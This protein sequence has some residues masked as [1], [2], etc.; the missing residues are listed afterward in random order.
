MTHGRGS[1][2]KAFV[3]LSAFIVVSVGTIGCTSRPTTEEAL[4]EQAFDAIK[5]NDWEAYQK[6]TITY[7]D[8]LLKAHK[9][10]R[11]EE[12]MSYAGD[13]LKP[14]ELQSQRE[15]FD[16]AVA[17]GK[18]QIDFRRTEFLGA[19]PVFLESMME[20]LTAEE[21]VPF[22]IYALK[23]AEGGMQRETRDLFP[24][25]TVV[26]WEGE[27]RIMRLEFPKTDSP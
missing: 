9:T 6:L 18:G 17:G 13:V 20:L 23:I 2:R 12:Q 22:K 1:A 10:S 21:K 11:V 26:P 14:E 4:L 25:F 27:Y 16:R 8:F 7:A 5:E 24:R 3:I 15:Q 19:G